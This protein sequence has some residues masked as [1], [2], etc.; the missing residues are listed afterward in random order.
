LDAD[1]NPGALRHWPAGRQIGRVGGG[2]VAPKLKLELRPKLT[3]AL[4]PGGQSALG[5]A[6]LKRA[7]LERAFEPTRWPAKCFRRINLNHA[8]QPVGAETRLVSQAEQMR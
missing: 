5:L 3:P 7:S 6:R 2:G 1:S 8:H 4:H